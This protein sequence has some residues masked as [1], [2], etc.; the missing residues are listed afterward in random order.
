MKY[1][2]LNKEESV[3]NAKHGISD[4][5]TR[6][7]ARR[8]VSR[9]IL[10]AMLA[11]GFSVP[12]QAINISGGLAA[13]GWTNQMQSTY[14]M[15]VTLAT[16]TVPVRLH[17]L[18]STLQSQVNCKVYDRNRRELPAGGLSMPLHISA[19]RSVNVRV[20]IFPRKDASVT[21]SQLAS[22]QCFLSVNGKDS[23][24]GLTQM[25][26]SGTTYRPNVGGNF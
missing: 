4:R 10:A 25:H 11:L 6:K 15:N 8:H 18:S 2:Q 12:A 24:S 16:I 22:W 9:L 7:P 26:Q 17:N 5:I 23:R 19:D 20:D 3:M 14:N 1:S 13:V 21:A